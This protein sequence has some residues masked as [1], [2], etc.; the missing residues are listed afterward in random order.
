M[1]SQRISVCLGWR[2]TV[3]S[4]AIQTSQSGQHV[5]VVRADQT[6]ELRPVVVERT[7]QSDS[8][9]SGGLKD[10]E[11][12]VVEGQLRVIPG[13]SVVVKEPPAPGGEKRAGKD[14]E[15]KGR[16]KDKGKKTP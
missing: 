16:K 12:V 7:Y 13:K 4:S 10:G 15:G 11:T 14:G 6:A 3:A 1:H 2:L 8:V 9:I 5:F